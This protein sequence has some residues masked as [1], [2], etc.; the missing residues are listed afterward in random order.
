MTED[1]RNG[2][3]IRT[4]PDAISENHPLR[5]LFQSLVQ[6]AFQGTL[7]IPQQ[8]VSVY[9]ANLLTDFAHRDAIYRLRD[10]QGKSLTDVADM[11][12]EGDVRLRAASFDREREV[13][14]HIGDFTLFWSGVY[15]EEMMQRRA[16][17]SRDSLLDYVQQG[18]QSYYI[19]STFR[20]GPYARESALFQQLSQEFE[21]IQ[22]GLHLVRRDWERLR[23]KER[24][25]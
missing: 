15:P 3:E 4:G 24:P 9:I 23:A 20:H 19:V 11:L 22:Y 1:F 16:R 17:L 25:L 18:K 8:E 13:H 2:Q 21:L 6:R 7:G 10:A 14:K 12:M 5:L